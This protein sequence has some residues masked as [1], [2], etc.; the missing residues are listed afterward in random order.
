M[1]IIHNRKKKKKYHFHTCYE[2]IST[3]LPF[4]ELQTEA[5]EAET[6]LERR[7]E[8]AGSSA[9]LLLGR[10]FVRPSNSPLFSLQIRALIFTHPIFLRK[11]KWDRSLALKWRIFPYCILSCHSQRASQKLLFV[12]L[13]PAPE[14]FTQTQRAGNYDRR[15]QE[16]NLMHNSCANIKK[17]S[18]F[19]S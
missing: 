7:M 12:R 14:H 9:V 1:G 11:W 2:V 4:W 17:K 13:L 3:S 15:P 18:Q 6:D 8:D 19:L 5:R 10:V 16:N